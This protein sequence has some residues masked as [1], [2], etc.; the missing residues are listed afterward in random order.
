MVA[1][2]RCRVESGKQ[3]SEIQLGKEM[4]RIRGIEISDSGILPVRLYAAVCLDRHQNEAQSRKVFVLGKIFPQGGFF[5]LVK[6]GIDTVHAAV[7]HDQLCRC[8]FT[9]FGNTGNI[10]RAVAH[11]RL[12]MDESFRSHLIRF[13]D[14]IGIIVLYD[15]LPLSGL[16]DPDAGVLRGDLQKVSVSRQKRD[17]HSLGF[18]APCQSPENVI[19]F[20]ACLFADLDSH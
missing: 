15:S 14:I 9:D 6:V 7:V 13:Q 12:D 20:K 5:D 4:K 18:P 3:G 8:L 19:R 16:G 17:F 10:V 2:S 11:E 1:C